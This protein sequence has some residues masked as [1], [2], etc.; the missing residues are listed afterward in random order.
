MK[1][2]KIII[3]LLVIY[4]LSEFI[5]FTVKRHQLGKLINKGKLQWNTNMFNLL[6]VIPCTIAFSNADGREVLKDFPLHSLIVL[7]I[8]IQVINK[9]LT[10]T[11]LYE[12]GIVKSYKTISLKHLRAYEWSDEN[13]QLYLKMLVAERKPIE[14]VAHLVKFKVAYNEKGKY[15]K[16]L[17]IALL[18]QSEEDKFLST[19]S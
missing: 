12:K 14:D 2:L 15:E 8:M 19:V 16:L 3:Y 4:Y 5:V 18:N 13:G 1:I 10:K 7:I 11:R 9:S 6:G 17:R